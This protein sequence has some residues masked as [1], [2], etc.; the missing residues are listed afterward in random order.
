MALAEML[1][2]ASLKN[3]SGPPGYAKTIP[4]PWKHACLLLNLNAC[5]IVPHTHDFIICTSSP[6][7]RDENGLEDLYLDFLHDQK[8]AGTYHINSEVYAR[9]ALRCIEYM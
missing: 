4:F 3:N 2:L 8:R 6:T 7:Y 1:E 9:V 5:D